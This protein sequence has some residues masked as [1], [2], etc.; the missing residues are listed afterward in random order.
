MKGP[1]RVYYD[2]ESD[3]LEISVGKPTKCYADEVKPGIFLRK[4]EKT[5]EIKSIGILSFKKRSAAKDIEL[6]LPV[7]IA[8]S[9]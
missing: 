2:E 4:D 7:N 6:N 9:V 1:M 5:H 3:F 8:I